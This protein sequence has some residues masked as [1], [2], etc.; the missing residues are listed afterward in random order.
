M[1]VFCQLLLKPVPVQVPQPQIL[2]QHSAVADD[3]QRQS[4]ILRLQVQLF[5]SGWL[6]GLIKDDGHPAGVF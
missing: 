4:L 2:V 5:R 6:V 3:N 1:L